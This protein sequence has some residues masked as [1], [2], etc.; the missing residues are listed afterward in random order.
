MDGRTLQSSTESGSH[1][2]A[3][4]ARVSACCR[5]ASEEVVFP[6]R[7]SMTSAALRLA[8]QRCGPSA[9]ALISEARGVVGAVY[10]LMAKNSGLRVKNGKVVWATAQKFCCGLAVGYTRYVRGDLLCA[11]TEHLHGVNVCLILDQFG[12]LISCPIHEGDGVES[13]RL[14]RSSRHRRALG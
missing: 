2:Q 11:F 10:L 7:M 9:S 3:M 1:T 4:P 13:R 8:V 14:R 5:A 12:E 6:W